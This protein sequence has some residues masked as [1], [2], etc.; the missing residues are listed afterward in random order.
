MHMMQG[1]C[2]KKGSVKLSKFRAQKDEQRKEEGEEDVPRLTS[3]KM[4]AKL[5]LALGSIVVFLFHRD[6]GDQ[7]REMFIDSVS[8]V[9][10]G[11][12]AL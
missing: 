4:E 8:L 12:E 11:P 7:E 2:P 9:L 1:T 6:A 5:E 3:K 10:A